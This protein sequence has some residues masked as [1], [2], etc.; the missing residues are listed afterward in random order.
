MDILARS[1][2]DR[3]DFLHAKRR[4]ALLV[5]LFG[6]LQGR[7]AELTAIGRSS[8]RATTPKHRIKAVDR[9]LGNDH[10]HDELLPLWG[11]IAHLL[12]QQTRRIVVLVDWTKLGAHHWTLSASVAISGRA[13][14]ILEQTAPE[15][16]LGTRAQH[17]AFL[18]R[19]ASVLPVGVEAV[20]VTDAGFESPWFDA[21][22]AMGWHFVGR[23]RRRVQLLGSDGEWF[24]NKQLHVGATATPE[25]L[26]V[27]AFPNAK[28][29]WGRFVRVKERPRG[30]HRFGRRGHIRRHGLDRQYSKT[31]AEPWV[32]VTSLLDET[33]DAIVSL[34]RLRMRVEEQFRDTKN[35]RW[36]WGLGRIVVRRNSE[37]RLDVLLLLVALAMLAMVLLGLAGQRRGLDRHFQANTVR[38]RPVL[39][40]FVLGTLIA[41]E[42]VRF[43][44]R[45]LTSLLPSLRRQILAALSL[46]PTV[47]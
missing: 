7:R 8:V 20:L 40:T 33:A 10:L 25:D 3:L 39:S 14:P 42:Q 38:N 6:L 43:P 28:P 37:N 1:L 26:G 23:V 15:A 11:V 24:C 22:E 29:R 12:L 2:R 32:L 18:N 30:R 17:E 46:F 47:K 16:E 34:Y 35:E 9:F 4:Q 27:M 13:L 19:L 44:A 31:A 41:D 45:L 36:G 21:V 5:A